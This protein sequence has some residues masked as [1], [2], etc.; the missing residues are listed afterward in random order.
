MEVRVLG[1]RVEPIVRPV[2]NANAAGF[3]INLRAGQLV[4]ERADVGV[5]A[6]VPALVRVMPVACVSPDLSCVFC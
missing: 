4:G 5:R 6:D 1:E 3:T 2:E